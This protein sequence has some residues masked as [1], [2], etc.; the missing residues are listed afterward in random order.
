MRRSLIAAGVLIAIML[1]AVA[2]SPNRKP[3]QKVTVVIHDEPYCASV[4][5]TGRRVV[6]EKLHHGPCVTADYAAPDQ[7]HTR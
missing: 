1:I 7:R 5:T 4:I 2:I 3:P 6:I